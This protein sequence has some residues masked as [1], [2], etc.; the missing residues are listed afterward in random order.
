MGGEGW[1]AGGILGVGQVV[2]GVVRL[3]PGG[4]G[5]RPRGRVAWVGRREGGVGGGGEI[6]DGVMGGAGG[7]GGKGASKSC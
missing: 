6:R 5:F 4:L 7:R 2:E 3:R 1:R